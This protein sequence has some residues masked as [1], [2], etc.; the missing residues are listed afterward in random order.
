MS[1][2]IDITE[3]LLD[4]CDCD[5][6]GCEPCYA[7]EVIRRLRTAGDEVVLTLGFWVQGVQSC[8]DAYAALAAW[9]EARRG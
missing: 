9:Q 7:A 6:Y 5:G 4:Y 1:G 8:R 2:D 3:T